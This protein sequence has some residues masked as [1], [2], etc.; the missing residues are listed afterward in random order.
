[1][2]NTDKEAPARNKGKAPQTDE[3][4]K[5]KVEKKPQTKAKDAVAQ[6]AS[7]KMKAVV[8]AAP[9]PKPAP[10]ARTKARPER[11]VEAGNA[12]ETETTSAEAT[13]G[14]AQAAPVEPAQPA[15]V[16]AMEAD[17]VELEPMYAPASK[18]QAPIEAEEESLTEAKASPAQSEWKPSEVAPVEEESASSAEIESADIQKI[19]EKLS[20]REKIE[21]E[22]SV[23]IFMADF[24]AIAAESINYSKKSL[25]NGGALVEQLLAAKSFESAIQIGSDFVQKSCTDFVA[26]LT[27]IGAMY[28]KLAGE[29]LK[30]PQFPH[31]GSNIGVIFQLVRKR[32]A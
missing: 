22:K 24:N 4:A 7:T 26:Y 25:E 17:V 15:L 28:A 32:S 29:A 12:P 21:P 6:D 31:A 13:E 23:T 5:T 19:G 11:V 18:Q 30:Q 9:L 27:T 2:N 3:A 16:E 20:E 1:M 10:A 14:V 8:P